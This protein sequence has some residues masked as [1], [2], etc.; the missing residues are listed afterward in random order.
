MDRDAIVAAL[1]SQY[2][3]ALE[4]LRSAILRTPET[5]WD[6]ADYE[7]RTWRLAYHA[8]WGVRFYLGGSPEVFSP[9]PGA[10]DGA[11]SLGGSWEPNGAA[12]V[13]GVHSPR[14]LIGFLDSLLE[15]LPGAVE[16]LPPE[17]PS[18]FEWFPFSRFELHVHSI[19]HTQHHTAQL[20]ERARA[21]HQGG[22]N[23]VAGRN[24]GGW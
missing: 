17:A 4:M 22:F 10:I 13:E 3:G 5:I 12:K 20:I 16:A 11:E 21:H 18:G 2:V 19:R 1:V 6:S 15:D 23:W 8:L 14:D 9:W 7:N 24:L